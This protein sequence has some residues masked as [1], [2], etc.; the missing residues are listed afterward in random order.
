MSSE[1]T[2]VFFFQIIIPFRKQLTYTDNRVVDYNVMVLIIELITF[3]NR[4]PRQ[5]K[6]IYNVV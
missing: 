5:V 3:G 6:N 4:A 2:Q 1:N